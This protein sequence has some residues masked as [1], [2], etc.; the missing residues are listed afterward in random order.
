MKELENRTAFGTEYVQYK[1]VYIDFK[2]K[3]KIFYRKNWSK[4]PKGKNWRETKF[5]NEKEFLEELGYRYKTKD[6]WR[7]IEEK[8]K[9]IDI[10]NRTIIDKLD[11]IDSKIRQYESSMKGGRIDSLDEK[12]RNKYFDLCNK[13]KTISKEIK[14]Y[15]IWFR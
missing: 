10:Q 5:T 6:T 13:R 3:N 12:E 15:P 14:E 1:K 9:E 4:S 2:K 8:R 7:K 11:I